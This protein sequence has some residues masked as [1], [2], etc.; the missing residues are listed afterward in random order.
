MIITIF[1]EVN[2]NVV[3]KKYQNNPSLKLP[4][5]FIC[6]FTPVFQPAWETFIII[7]FYMVD[8]MFSLKNVSRRFNNCYN[9]IYLRI[10][11]WKTAL[12]PLFFRGKNYCTWINMAVSDPDYIGIS[13]KP[14]FDNFIEV[15][16]IL[17][18][19]VHVQFC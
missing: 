10:S 7:F 14:H 1:Y 9:S 8:A 3:S 17:R 13:L 5:S 6:T 4:D 19:L 2:Q 11:W 16:L 15:T 12:T 18:L